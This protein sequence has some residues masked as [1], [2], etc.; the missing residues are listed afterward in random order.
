VNKV[1]EK[2]VEKKELRIETEVLIFKLYSPH[3]EVKCEEG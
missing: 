2:N 3:L 1:N